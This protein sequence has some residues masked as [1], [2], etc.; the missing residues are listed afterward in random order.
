MDRSDRVHS[1]GSRESWRDV[2]R[3]LRDRMRR[4]L[5]A[6]LA[7]ALSGCG[8]SL[9][10]PRCVGSSRYSVACAAQLSEYADR[11][12]RE[13]RPGDALRLLFWDLGASPEPP[14]GWSAFCDEAHSYW[15]STVYRWMASRDLDQAR[16]RR[17]Q[18][19]EQAAA[20]SVV[21]VAP[22]V[23]TAWCH[24]IAA[25][26]D[27]DSWWD[28][29]HADAHR[30]LSQLPP[31]ERRGLEDV[32]AAL[33]LGVLRATFESLRERSWE[34]V[35]TEAERARSDPFGDG[36]TWL[37]AP[38]RAL[39]E[40][41]S[42][43]FLARVEA[44]SEA[45][46]ARVDLA[47]SAL[48][49]LQ[50]WPQD[51]TLN[52]LRQRLR[53]RVIDLSRRRVVEA[54]GLWT[55]AGIQAVRQMLTEFGE[56]G[57]PEL[58]RQTIDLM[59][60]AA[61]DELAR[62][63]AQPT[64]RGPSLR[65]LRDALDALGTRDAAVASARVEVVAAIHRTLL[66]EHDARMARWQAFSPEMFS[67]AQLAREEIRAEGETALE[68]A[69]ELALSE[70]VRRELASIR[71][72]RGNGAWLARSLFMAADERMGPWPPALQR[73]LDDRRALLVRA[74]L[75]ERDALLR[76]SQP[77]AA[78]LLARRLRRFQDPAVAAEVAQTESAAARSHLARARQAAIGDGFATFHLAVVRSLAPMPPDPHVTTEPRLSISNR[79]GDPRCDPLVQQMSRELRAILALPEARW[80]VA[81]GLVTRCSVTVE[82]E[83]GHGYNR[84][85]LEGG[86]RLYWPGGSMQL[87]EGIVGT[88]R[89]TRGEPTAAQALEHNLEAR[90]DVA[91]RIGQADLRDLR[92][93]GHAT[94]PD[95]WLAEADQRRERDPDGALDLYVWASRFGHALSDE[96]RAW[97]SHRFGVSY[98]AMPV[99]G[100]GM[101]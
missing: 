76:R 79:T 12:A 46:A 90:G 36:T 74:V 39:E 92:P 78:A 6:A 75:D 4:T 83:A 5:G 37:P 40:G 64:A 9:I 49:A 94:G 23:S 20:A 52:D 25:A 81:R 42:A 18:L 31:Q 28:H 96:Q 35:L 58:E 59:A 99:I 82:S 62:I 72:P 19:C 57:D 51:A 24:Q 54:S 45:P 48:R 87:S 77:W 17:R 89:A 86:A 69:E 44:S 98:A 66:S 3:A 33:Q 85:E 8:T 34:N 56:D 91:L 100:I 10:P 101:M 15:G 97:M 61:R 38:Q 22:Q 11:S 14:D 68:T 84:Y 60:T 16:G 29:P 7:L 30:C 71:G 88:D 32:L 21:T 70:L 26:P 93:G 27:P 1:H 80:M 47:R 73:V 2:S 95:A 41:V 63:Q 65:A 43:L 55:T 13:G 50:Q 53:A 67:D